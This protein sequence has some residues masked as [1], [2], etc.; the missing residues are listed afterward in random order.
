MFKLVAL[1]FLLAN[2]EEPITAMSYN[3]KTFPSKDTCAAFVKDGTATA[4]L[5]KAAAEQSLAVKFV[6]VEAEDN[7]I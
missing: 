1:L 4:P 3:Q 5:E 7:T 2:P 6:C